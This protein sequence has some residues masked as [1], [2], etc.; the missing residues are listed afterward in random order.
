MSTRARAQYPACFAHATAAHYGAVSSERLPE[1]YTSLPLLTAA[2]SE[3]LSC[4]VLCS[5]ENRVIVSVL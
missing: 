2:P 5:L 3:L 1:F 4:L